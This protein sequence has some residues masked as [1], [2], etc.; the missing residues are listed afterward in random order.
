MVLLKA[1]EKLS[2]TSHYSMLLTDWATQ[3]VPAL[4]W[5]DPVRTHEHLAQ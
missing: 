2:H 4:T 1:A 5:A 3:A